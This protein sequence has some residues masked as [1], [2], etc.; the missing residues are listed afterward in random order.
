MLTG[1]SFSKDDPFLTDVIATLNPDEYVETFRRRLPEKTGDRINAILDLI[2][3]QKKYVGRVGTGSDAIRHYCAV[4]KFDGVDMDQIF[5]FWLE[6]DM[7]SLEDSGEFA[8]ENPMQISDI[9]I[10]EESEVKLWGDI[11]DAVA[12][13][14]FK[15]MWQ[16]I[17]AMGAKIT[18][19]VVTELPELISQVD[20]NF[21]LGDDF[22]G[23]FARA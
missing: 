4:P 10:S 15:D 16:K 5:A 20:P 19:M 7:K 6:R 14:T 9:G 2:G 11:W 23:D 3:Y 1:E 13:D 8:G 21:A 22:A 18:R 17:K 12:N